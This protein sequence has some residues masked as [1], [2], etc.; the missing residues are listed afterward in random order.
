[1]S[2]AA[3]R[4]LSGSHGIEEEEALIEVYNLLCGH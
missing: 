2:V 3:T 1:M 4:Q